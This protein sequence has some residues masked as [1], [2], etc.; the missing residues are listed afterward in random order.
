MGR[1]IN[2]TDQMINPIRW[3]YILAPIFWEAT[4]RSGT[5]D[6]AKGLWCVESQLIGSKAQDGTVLLVQRQ[7]VQV[8]M[9]TEDGKIRRDARYC[10]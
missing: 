10:P 9:A 1:I 6:I 3:G 7:N 5:V 4:A 2:R 8:V